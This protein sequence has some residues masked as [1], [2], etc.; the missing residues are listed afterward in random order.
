LRP[1]ETPFQAL[2]ELIAEHLPGSAE[3]AGATTGTAD[4]ETHIADWLANHP[5]QKL[6]LIVDQF[7]ELVTLC[8]DALARE[9]FQQLLQTLL[10]KHSDQLRIILT[11]RTDFEPQ[12]ATSPLVERWQPG[13]F[14]VPPM[15]QAESRTVIEGPAGVRVLFFEPPELVDTLIDEV[16]QTPGALP[17][18]SFTLEQLYLKYL[19]RQTA[20]Q[21]VG[22]TI[23][24]ALTHADYLD[25]GGVIGSLRTR[26][27]EE[28]K[29]LPDDAHRATMERVM[30]RMIAIEGGEL[31]RRR[32]PMTELVY[33]SAAEN[34]RGA[35][36]IERLVGARL[37]VMDSADAHGDG[38]A[39]AY[40]EPAH[41]ALVRA[42]DRLLRWKQGFEEYLSLQRT[43]TAAAD[44]WVREGCD[45]KSGLLW[46]NN[47]RLPQLQEVLFPDEFGESTNGG[48]L[49]TARQSLWPPTKAADAPTWLNQQETEFVR[50]SV[51]RR[52]NVLKRIASITAAVVLILSG[53][54]ASAIY[55]QQLATTNAET[56]QRN[57]ATANTERDRADAN[58]AEAEANA[59]EAQR[60]AIEAQEN[61]RIAQEN[62]AAAIRAEETAVAER[63]EAQ[64]QAR[65]SR[66][67][68]LTSYGQSLRTSQRYSDDVT[69]ILARDAIETT[70]NDDGYVTT[71]ASALLFDVLADRP[72]WQLSLPSQRH[73]DTINGHAGAITAAAWNPHGDKIATASDDGAAIIWDTQSGQE[74]LYISVYTETV[75]SIAWNPSG[76][77]LATTDSGGKAKI[78][79]ANTGA[80]FLELDHGCT[81]F[82][83]LAG[84]EN[85]FQSGGECFLTVTWS[86]DG[87]Q[88][89]TAGTNEN[90]KIWD[91]V[92]GEV[93]L[94]IEAHND[95]IW[96][97]DWSG[98][99]KYLAT[100]SQDR[101]VKIW[102]AVSG[103]EV[104]TLE[105]HRAGVWSVRWSPD[106][107]KVTTAGWDNEA[108]VWS[109][110]SGN[111]LL[112]LTHSEPV[113]SAAWHPSGEHILTI[114][115]DNNARIWNAESGG[116]VERIQI[117]GETPFIDETFSF[118]GLGDIWSASW[119]PDGDH[120]LTTS[121]LRH[122]DIWKYASA[123]VQLLLLEHQSPIYSIDW[124]PDNLSLLTAS[125]DGTATVWSA[126][127]G[128]ERFTLKGH[129][130]RIREAVWNPEGDQIAT[131][132]DDS[133][134]RIWNAETGE[135]THAIPYYPIFFNEPTPPISKATLKWHPAQN[136]LLI[137]A[138]WYAKIWDVQSGEELVQIKHQQ[139]ED[140]IFSRLTD[141]IYAAQFD[142]DGKQ[143]V[144]SGGDGTARI[145]RVD[146]PQQSIILDGHDGTVEFTDWS[147]DGR[148]VATGSSDG[149]V[150]VWQVDS[151][152]ELLTL[153]GHREEVNHLAWSHD[154]RHIA[155][156][157]SDNMVKIW[158]TETGLELFSLVGHRGDILQV[159]WSNDD[160]LIA[161]ASSDGTAGVW[162]ASPEQWL[163]Q[164]GSRIQRN[165]A[166][167]SDDEKWRYG[168]R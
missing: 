8:R 62:E 167:L 76:D 110:D 153:A 112:S 123:P 99:G 106:N 7:E 127:S 105:G 79:D 88:L 85:F 13:R 61:A 95:D 109:S 91:A 72:H 27:D 158:D 104:R 15:T 29:A 97:I 131:L 103:T 143:V 150:K 124:S 139:G 50:T 10:D 30:L 52:A 117:E 58:A 22:D 32:V 140:N 19:K 42:W 38:V 126:I 83:S 54:T 21:A 39:D 101:T 49:R 28:Y 134:V 56:A 12:F 142:P 155:T 114:S 45:P 162:W 71:N 68:T 65:L 33:P 60:N 93:N 125:E 102:D 94:T 145:W 154:D 100:A 96:G 78:W 46:N 135:Q 151:G 37:L 152:D 44:E 149:T 20:A 120:L 161:T 168:Q 75:Y 14:V 36:V 157:S 84:M 73:T 90:V 11:L 121:G 163:V 80:L 47:P 4:I 98:D 156:A 51:V 130:K 48:F 35:T 148:R 6:L 146:S 111:E 128:Y 23:E 87:K 107:R 132:S 41:D 160:V 25:L 55:Q 133:T 66:S 141:E 118:L 57:E 70:L 43:L 116:L 18:L 144:T 67:E 82:N 138:E 137:A 53:I 165:I 81:S 122:L 63:N 2:A 26:A 59:A 147:H 3:L 108:K 113:W 69:L 16:I 40:V 9:A 34:V 86:P 159:A 24:R 129:E 115:W 17:L 119:S 31:A 64:R 77:R 1:T 92:M 164:I 74:Y 89:A 5:D 166:V 136:R